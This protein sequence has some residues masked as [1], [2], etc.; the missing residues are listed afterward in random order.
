MLRSPWQWTC[1]HRTDLTALAMVVKIEGRLFGA[2]E[3]WTL[4]EHMRSRGERDGVDYA[5]WSAQGFL[6][7]VP[8]STLEYGPVAERIAQL[9]EVSTVR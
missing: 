8:G 7:A 9:A 4:P 6:H 2:V 1:R 5:L 3:F